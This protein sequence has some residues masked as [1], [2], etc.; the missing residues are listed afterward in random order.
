MIPDLL[1]SHILTQWSQPL[2]GI[3]VL[4]L[5]SKDVGSVAESALESCCL[6]LGYS[7]SS[8]EQTARLVRRAR[9]TKMLLYVRTVEGAV[10]S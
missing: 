6:H 9:L 2:E 8:F 10:Y 3:R 5:V 7:S 1:P 4:R